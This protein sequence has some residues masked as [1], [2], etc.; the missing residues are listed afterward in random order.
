MPNTN[1]FDEAAE[2]YACRIP[3]LPLFFEKA[4]KQLALHK[5]SR[6]MDLA[7]GSGELA[8]G[9]SN[10]LS[11]IT[12]IDQSERMLEL[13]R[14]RVPD[15]VSLI[16][17]DLNEP[18]ALDIG[19]FDVIVIGRAL[20]YL[21]KDPLFKVLDQTLTD[22]GSTLVCGSGL[23][24]T[25]PW[26]NTYVRTVRPFQDMSKPLDP[27]WRK[28]FENTQ[29]E[30]SGVITRIGEMRFSI[31]DL[32]NNMLSYRAFS[33]TIRENLGDFRSQLAEA[34]S[35]YFVQENTLMGTVRSYGTRYRR[36]KAD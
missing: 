33:L 10:Y 15:N 16:Q 31:N 11:K 23:Q 13:A 14:S 2:Y 25:T 26:A 30:N 8:V 6:L 36:R 29:F 35:P 21:K 7:C 1:S 28:L 24:Q 12:A 34:L 9:F 20:R 18:F 5:G 32:V 27:S 19:Y 3:Y 4:S 17:F 22:G